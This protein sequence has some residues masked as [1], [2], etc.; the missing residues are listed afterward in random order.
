MNLVTRL[1]NRRQGNLYSVSVRGRNC[2]SFHIT[3]TGSG[4]YSVWCSKGTAGF[5]QSRYRD[6]GVNSTTHFHLAP[7]LRV[8]SRFVSPPPISTYGMVLV[9][10][11]IDGST[12]YC[13]RSQPYSWVIRYKNL[14]RQ[15]LHSFVFAAPPWHMPYVSNVRVCLQLL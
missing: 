10:Q 7:S 5:L 9:V 8:Q 3:Q 6:R 13:H 1:E 2:S 4:T 14:L 12:F 15:F 11:I